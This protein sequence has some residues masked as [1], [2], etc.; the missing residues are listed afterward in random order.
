MWQ[1]GWIVTVCV[2][3]IQLMVSMFPCTVF[4]IN[5]N[6]NILIINSYDR[7]MPW[8]DNETIGI[9]NTYNQAGIEPAFYIEYLD[10]KNSPNPD[11]ISLF[12]QIFKSKYAQ[13]TIDIVMTT[14]DK[15]LE[16]ALNYQ[17]ELFHNAP[18]V[19]CG[20]YPASAEKMA[21][22]RSNVTGVYEI[23]DVEGTLKLMNGLTPDLEQ[24]YLI[25]DN[26][27]SGLAARE[28][29]E[30]AVHKQKLPL[31]VVHMNDFSYQEINRQLLSAP[32][33]SAVLIAT[34]S[35]DAAG[36]NMDLTRYA[37]IFSQNSRIPIYI[38]Y[39]FNVGVGT[40]GGSVVSGLQQGKHAAELGMRIFQGEQPS[41]IAPVSPANG[42]VTVDYQQLERLKLPVS[43]IP[44]NSVII[45]NP[46]TFYETNKEIIW[47]VIC[48]FW[49]LIFYIVVL[50]GNIK[51]RKTAEV[52]LKRNNEEITALYEEVL[53]SQ[54]ELQHQYQQTANVRDALGKSEERYKLSVEG[55]NDG[56]WDWDIIRDE[57]Y[58]SDRCCELLAIS[59]N[60]L[61][62]FR[63][64]LQEKIPQG[65]LSLVLA[66]LD[67]H[68]SGES[69]YFVLEEKMNTA[70]GP[71]WLLLRGKALID[72]SGRPLRMAGSLTDITDRK[73]HEAKI[74][75]L[76]YH[77]S[78]TGLANRTALEKELEDLLDHYPASQSGALL[79][80]DIDNFKVI[81]DTFGHSYGDKMLVVMGNLLADS[82]KGVGSV[83]RMGGDEFVLLLKS[84]E[85]QQC[86]ARLAQTIQD[87]LSVPLQINEKNFDVTLSIGVTI[88]PQDG[89]SKEELLKNADLAMYQAKVQGK[90]KCIF[91]SRMMEKAVLEKVLLE[92]SLREAIVNDELRLWYQPFVEVSTGKIIGFEALIRWYNPEKG[93]VMPTQFIDL[94][95]ETGLIIPIG[96][97]ILR[98]ACRFIV[99]L[100]QEG[101]ENLKVTVNLSIVQLMQSDFV[102]SVRNIME[103]TG[104]APEWIGLEI[105]EGILMESIEANIDKLRLIKDLGIGIYLD[106]FG[107]G[108][109]SLNYLKKLPIDVVK[110]DKSFID[111]LISKESEKQLTEVIIRLA[112][113]LGIKTVAEGVETKAQLEQLTQYHCDVVQGYLFSKPVP[114]REVRDLLH[115]NEKL[116]R[117]FQ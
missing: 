65:E 64:F 39:D 103:E 43:K 84:V 94:A 95:E 108:Y 50:I 14:D 70:H 72:S 66:Q 13:R 28:L 56:L 104:A 46:L 17:T 116:L 86:P 68:L 61:Q 71:T 80:V 97:H 42:V 27:E 91:F 101:Y 48:A 36:T 24:L 22:G 5:K 30:S 100:R 67:E 51:R 38:L 93:L 111:D 9:I 87:V 114:E 29:L 112:H 8:T 90:N 58:F 92:R 18:I 45:N 110:I 98:N 4:A 105:T 31:S 25:Y 82:S 77:D 89:A 40:I 41:D 37:Q 10:W 107:T 85:D 54:D 55:A 79:F 74:N 115:T 60:Q 78:L 113:Q 47:S 102:Q 15:A 99:A 53:A 6:P 73:S 12:Y 35:R 59:S 83:F 23:M 20:V 75:Y 117:E 81:N 62:G 1:K 96:Q 88:F 44:P 7:N 21:A 49:V 11:N 52:N 57:V 3:I 33:N 19:F 76:A 16:F 69:A 106:D 109:S 32:D 26:T 63:Q 2:T 34:Y